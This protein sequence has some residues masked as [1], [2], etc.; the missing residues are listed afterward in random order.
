MKPFNTDYDLLI[1]NKN[2]QNNQNYVFPQKNSIIKELSFIETRIL[3]AKV[4]HFIGLMI[5]LYYISIFSFKVEF[6]S[7]I[8]LFPIFIAGIIMLLLFFLRL[9]SLWVNFFSIITF[10]NSL[11]VSGYIATLKL[12]KILFRERYKKV[13]YLGEGL[14]LIDKGRGDFKKIFYMPERFGFIKK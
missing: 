4:L 9:V 11:F 1:R 10:G 2:F 14:Y 6:I 13:Y 8:L 5:L 7:K 12:D 3:G